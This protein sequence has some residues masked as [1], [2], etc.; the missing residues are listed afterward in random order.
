MMIWLYLWRYMIYGRM[1]VDINQ[2]NGPLDLK[3]IR[4]YKQYS[5]NTLHI[6][7]FSGNWI[8]EGKI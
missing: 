6:T 3:L 5:N 2:I 7:R 1:D 4:D 8:C